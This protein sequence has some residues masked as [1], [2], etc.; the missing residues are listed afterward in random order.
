MQQWHYEWAKEVFRVLKPGAHLLA[1]SG[2]RTYHRL[3]CAI[4]DAG[5]E[6]RDQIHWLYGS[7]FPKGQNI[8]L[9]INKTIDSLIHNRD[10]DTIW[11]KTHNSITA[12][13]VVELFQR[14]K[15]GVGNLTEKRDSVVV[16]V[17]PSLKARKSKPS[18]KNVEKK[19]KGRRRTSGA[20]FIVVDSAEAQPKQRSLCVRIVELVS[21]NQ[22]PDLKDITSII[23]QLDVSTFLCEKI[24]DRI[25]EGAVQK[26]ALGELRYWKEM[27]MNVLFAELINDLRHIISSQCKSIPNSGMNSQMESP[28][29]TSVIITKSTMAH[30]TT[31][32]ADTLVALLK[33]RLLQN[34]EG[35][36]TQLKPAHEPIVLARKPISEKSIVENVLKYGTA[37]I[38]VDACRIAVSPDVDTIGRQAKRKDRTKPQDV[39]FGHDNPEN[40]MAGVLPTGRY[41]ANLIL[42]HHPDCKLIQRGRT[43]VRH[44]EREAIETT[45]KGIYSDGWIRNPNEYSFDAGGPEVWGCVE[46][47]PIRIL[48]EQSG[49]TSRTSPRGV[50]SYDR[51]R[52]RLGAHGIYGSDEPP[53]EHIQE[54]GDKGGSARFFYCAKP[55]VAERNAGIKG[56]RNVHITVKPLEIMKWLLR[57]VTPRG[58]IVLDPFLGSGTTAIAAENEGFKWLGCDN[59]EGYCEI[60]KA[61]IKALGGERIG[62]KHDFSGWQK[63]KKI[64]ESSK[65]ARGVFG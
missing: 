43:E 40:V 22:S 17:V 14:R 25:K 28:S 11:S 38:N 26:I 42:S 62:R 61:R 10:I 13:T 50:R 37:A 16:D 27:D 29:A 34:A 48:N 3:A 36:N 45:G 9:N 49:D 32:M 35:W 21:E 63:R 8:G 7:G 64:R 46:G 52:P 2:T 56:K 12:R 41:P 54:Y 18:A 51:S 55:S 6:I 30:L 31:F 24:M 19:L 5:F 44:T 47:C 33:E 1:F 65:S 53:D 60:A 58:G 39:W 20:M 23:V 15:T 59:N 57:L 4:E